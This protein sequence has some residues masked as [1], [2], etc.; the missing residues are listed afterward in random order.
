MTSGANIVNSERN[1]GKCWFDC[2]LA[3]EHFVDILYAVHK[4]IQLWFC[5]L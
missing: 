1:S 2:T 3:R 5:F 4:K